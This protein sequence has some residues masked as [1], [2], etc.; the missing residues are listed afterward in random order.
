M[1]VGESPGKVTLREKNSGSRTEPWRLPTF[2]G[3]QSERTYKETDEERN[4][5]KPGQSGIPDA[6]EEGSGRTGGHEVSSSS[7]SG[8][9]GFGC[10][11][12]ALVTFARSIPIELG[13][14]RESQCSGLRNMESA[15]FVSYVFYYHCYTS[16]FQKG[17]TSQL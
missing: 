15:Q 5:G 7:R 3:Q 1:K 4:Q 8:L 12:G 2:E 17:E 10:L 6:K 14:W 13:T 16:F 11:G 9:Y